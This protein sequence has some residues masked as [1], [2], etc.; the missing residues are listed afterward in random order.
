MFSNWYFLLT[1]LAGCAGSS[2]VANENGDSPE[3][4][5][6]N[7]AEAL[8]VQRSD[9][10]G[11]LEPQGGAWGGD[12]WSSPVYCNAGTW[13]VGFKQR[14]EKPQGS[15]SDDTSANA[16]EMTCSSGGVI[17]AGNDGKW[18]SWLGWSTCGADS[19]V[20]GLSLRMD[21]RDSSG[22]ETA[23]N[24]LRLFCCRQPAPI[25]PT[26]CEGHCGGQA[27]GGCWCDSLCTQ[28]GDCCGDKQNKC[29]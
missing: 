11:I 13:A 4:E 19:Y 6:S 23:M 12:F 16:A 18:G 2:D 7:G 10:T 25:P 27:P 15:S 17:N 24:G 5:A 20:C 21:Q 22:D 1:P 14:V 28:Y 8:S 29:G 26:S 9:Q 3:A